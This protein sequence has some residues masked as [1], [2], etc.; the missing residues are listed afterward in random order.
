MQALQDWLC[1]VFEHAAIELLPMSG[2]AGFRC[3]YRF[4]LNGRS[5]IAVD[6]PSAYS[7][8][9]AF[10]IMQ[11]ALAKQKI[12]VPD[13]IAMELEQGFFCLSDFGQT[14]LADV[15]TS[16]TMSQY[17][18]QAIQFLPLIA[19]TQTRLSEVDA[20]KVHDLEISDENTKLSD[21]QLPRYDSNFIQTELSIFTEWLVAKHLQIKMTEQEEQNLQQCF[22]LLI[23]NAISQPQVTMH[24]D[25]H[26][27]NIMML[28]NNQL[29]I[30]DFQDAVIGPITYDVVSLLRDCYTRWPEEQITP[31]F[32]Y[33]CQ[34]MT[35]K[36]SLTDA[37]ANNTNLNKTDLTQISPE[38]WQRWFDLMGLQRHLKA[39][40]IFSRLFYRDNKTGYLKDIPL[41]LLYIEDIS[42]RYPELKF[43]HHFIKYRVMPAMALK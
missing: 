9:K 22:D 1:E 20:L 15:L 43:L 10:A 23:T 30:I 27:R 37:N 39:S 41:T 19:T 24:R 40:G 2:D 4:T 29:G 5:L 3:Y 13:I 14:L 28:E 36:L 38:Q 18:Q 8:N 17:Y 42:E 21:C 26:S 12:C 16:A 25:Y 34:L 6:A 11:A 33:F 31:L 7:N 32:K 35:E